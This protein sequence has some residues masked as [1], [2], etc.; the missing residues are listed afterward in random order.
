[1]RGAHAGQGGGGGARGGVQVGH[2]RPDHQRAIAEPASEL[3]G[4]GQG[5]VG[6]AEHHH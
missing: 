3:L 2:H 5:V 4:R 1:M 6:A